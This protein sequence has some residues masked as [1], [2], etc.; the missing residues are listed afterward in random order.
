MISALVVFNVVPSNI[1]DPPVDVNNAMPTQ[2][3]VVSKLIW[4]S[5]LA[6]GATIAISRWSATKK[7]LARVN[8][9][10]LLFY[11]LIAASILWSIEPG[12]T[13][14]R[15]V[16]ASTI[17]LNGI[18]LSVS[19]WHPARFQNTLRPVLTLLLIASIIFVMAEPQLAIERSDRFELAGAWHGLTAQKNA[20]GALSAMAFLLWLHAY[21]SRGT[22]A[23]LALMGATIAGVCLINSRSSTSIMATAFSAVLM[24]MMLRSPPALRRLMPYLIAAFVSLLLIYS[25]AVLNLLPGSGTLLSPITSLTG[26]DLTFSGRTAIW[27]IM[28]EHIVLRPWLG[29]GYSAYWVQSPDSPSLLMLQRLYFYPTEGHNGYLDVINDL[30]AIGG[31]CLFAYLIM[32]LRQGLQLLRQMRPQGS[33]YLTLLFAQLIGNLSESRWFNC[34]DFN[35]VIM[36][37][38]TIAMGRTLLDTSSVAPATS[39]TVSRPNPSSAHRAM[40]RRS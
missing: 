5:L 24:L 29:S 25:L 19:A 3:T 35:F 21:L 22:S 15:L 23:W 33:L 4:L 28:N 38:A 1:L 37:I 6:L 11:G 26:K 7:L 12:I 10:L 8:P 34:L 9:F 39:T 31:L 20:F 13:M 32:F 18:A 2:G 17:L 30:G 27:Q 36:T 40:P 16:T 14:K